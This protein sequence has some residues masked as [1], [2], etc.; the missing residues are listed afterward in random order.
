MINKGFCHLPKPSGL[1]FRRYI[2]SSLLRKMKKEIKQRN[3]KLILPQEI[4]NTLL[5]S[6]LISLKIWG[7][8][9]LED[10]EL[11]KYYF[12]EKEKWLKGDVNEETWMKDIAKDLDV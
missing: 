12:K 10:K 2:M 4:Y 7:L 3:A 1:F 5:G 6:F 9:P 11:K 8:M